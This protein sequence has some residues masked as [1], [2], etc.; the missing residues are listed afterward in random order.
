MSIIISV[1]VLKGSNPRHRRSI[2]FVIW[3]GLCRKQADQWSEEVSKGE[4]MTRYPF[5]DGEVAS[6]L[7]ETAREKEEEEE[8]MTGQNIEATTKDFI[9]A[10]L[11]FWL[12]TP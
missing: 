9:K 5:H 6:D 12:L 8:A 3:A 10:L 7:R 2:S 11:I 4:R 1:T